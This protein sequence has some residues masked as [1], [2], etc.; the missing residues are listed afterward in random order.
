MHK[1]KITRNQPPKPRKDKEYYKSMDKIIKY[2]DKLNEAE[3]I[4]G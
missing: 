4:N 2:L 1:E 3:D